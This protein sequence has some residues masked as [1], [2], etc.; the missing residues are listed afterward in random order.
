MIRQIGWIS[1]GESLLFG[2]W[3]MIVCCP[4][5]FFDTDR[6][7]P[8]VAAEAWNR[9]LKRDNSVVVDNLAG[10]FKSKLVCP[11]CSKVKQHPHIS[12]DRVPQPL[13]FVG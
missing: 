4:F 7:D 1:G 13:I 6:P 3:L 2:N 12:V 11:Q 8:V 5:V 9:Y 10:Q